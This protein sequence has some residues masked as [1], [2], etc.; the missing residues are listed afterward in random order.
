MQESHLGQGFGVC[1]GFVPHSIKIKETDVLDI[2][3]SVVGHH[4]PGTSCAKVV[5]MFCEHDKAVSREGSWT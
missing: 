1:T 4:S 2:K 3:S 5:S